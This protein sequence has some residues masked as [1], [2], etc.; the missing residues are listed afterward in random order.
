MKY[1]TRMEYVKS[2][3]SLRLLQ[4]IFKKKSNICIDLSLC[5]FTDI[6]KTANLIGPYICILC[7][8]LNAYDELSTN[9]IFQLQSV[10]LKYDF[11]LMD[12]W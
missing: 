11:L 12:D 3:I 5:K 4:I 9:E 2:E 8:H 6:I 1:E 10:A 7:L